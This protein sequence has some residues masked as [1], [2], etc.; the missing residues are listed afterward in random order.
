MPRT[1]KEPER[2]NISDIRVSTK[3]EFIKR[4]HTDV[5]RYNLLLPTAINLHRANPTE[6]LDVRLIDLLD[7]I[8]KNAMGYML[9]KP[10]GARGEKGSARTRGLIVLIK[11]IEAH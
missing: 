5:R 11:Q 8:F 9:L 6:M 1:I 2:L 3:N 10:F 7:S 4:I